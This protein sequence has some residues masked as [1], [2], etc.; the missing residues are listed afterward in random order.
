MVP[1]ESRVVFGTTDTGSGPLDHPTATQ[2]DIEY[3]LKYL[4]RYLTVPVT[5]AD[6][7]STYAGYRPLIKPRKQNASTAKLSR[8]HAVL[9]NPT[10]LVSIVGGKLTTY[11]RM[12]QDTVDVLSKR[13]GRRLV[14]PTEALL[15]QGSTDWSTAKH[16]LQKKGARLGLAT[17]IVAHLGH[18]YGTGANDILDL[19]ANDPTLARRLIND[20]PYIVAEVIY[21]CRAEMAMTPDD[22]L[23][24]RTSIILEDKQRGLGIVDEVAA[25]MAR[26]HGWSLSE[27]EERARAYREAIQGQMA[28]EM[29][30]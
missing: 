14:H 2:V 21:G 26:E 3:L 13:D 24:R 15:L 19:I 22:I 30:S 18:S 16:E 29:K 12:A 10:G 27:Q 6:I 20:L 4:N 7:I 25:L 17:E 9:K 1:W 5:K 11:R 28:A 8:T 23:A